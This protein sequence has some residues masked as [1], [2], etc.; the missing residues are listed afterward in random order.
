MTLLHSEGFEFNKLKYTWWDCLWERLNPVKEQKLSWYRLD[1]YGPAKI[2]V[3][4]KVIKIPKGSY[5]QWYVKAQSDP[6]EVLKKHFSK[7]WF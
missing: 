6:T 2:A 1:I 7:K 3:D 5:F 4:S